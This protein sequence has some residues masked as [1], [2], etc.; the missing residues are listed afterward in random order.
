MRRYEYSDEI[1]DVVKRFLEDDEWNY[2]FDEKTGAFY[3]NLR[4]RSKIQRINYV[5]D[6]HED[7]LVTYGISPIA[8]DSDDP[9]VMRQMTEFICRANYGL[10]NGCFELELR[11]GEIRF[12]SFVD[13]K[14][15]IPSKDVVKNGV[16]C[17]AAMFK[18]YAPGIVDIIF[19]G[20][21]AKDAIAKCEESPEDEF[22]SALEEALGGD[23]SEESMDEFLSRLSSDLGITEEDG[24]SHEDENRPESIRLNPFIDKC[25]GR[26]GPG[27]SHTKVDLFAVEGGEA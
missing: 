15:L 2:F 6:V 7:E 18:R 12:R 20:A 17:T 21:S 9:E 25:N 11:D 8:A 10:K 19:S 24:D 16:H 27:Q 22:R 26:G 4:I 3:F 14:N 23:L 1:V 5:I 13:C